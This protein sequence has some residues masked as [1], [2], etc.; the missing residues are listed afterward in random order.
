MLDNKLPHET[1]C[2]FGH[3]CDKCHL[4]RR[5]EM[6]HPQRSGENIDKWDCAIVWSMMAGLDTGRQVVGLHAAMNQSQNQAD[7]RQDEFF[8]VLASG[9]LSV[10]DTR[11]RLSSGHP[12]SLPSPLKR[13]EPQRPSCPGQGSYGQSPGGD[14]GD[15]L[16]S[17]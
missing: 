1:S 7:K 5:V 17:D 8:D 3:T 6:Q 9:V 15:P 11:S 13:P 2:P 12:E 14:G 4:Y 16:P 10:A